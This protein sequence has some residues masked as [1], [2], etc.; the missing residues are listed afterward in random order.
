[1]LS[2]AKNCIAIAKKKIIKLKEQQSY[3]QLIL[4]EKV[5]KLEKEINLT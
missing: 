1:M 5:I 3:K 4:R 2:T